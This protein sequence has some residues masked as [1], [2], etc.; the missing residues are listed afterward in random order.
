[1]RPR[2]GVNCPVHWTRRPV[3]KLDKEKYG[4]DVEDV[5]VNVFVGPEM[6]VPK[7]KPNEALEWTKSEELHPFWFVKRCQPWD[8]SNMELIFLA[9][10]HIIACDCK[11]LVQA[12]GSDKPVTEV[13]QVSYACLVNTEDIEPDTELILAWSQKAVKAVPKA[14]KQ[15]NAFDQLADGEAKAKRA[16]LR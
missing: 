13:A 5:H 7:G 9:A 16:R 14:A 8:K 6:K 1:M 12:G 4:N 11:A 3:S 15:K 2:N 10:S